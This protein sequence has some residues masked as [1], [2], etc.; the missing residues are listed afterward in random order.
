MESTLTIAL[1]STSAEFL[2]A[3]MDEDNALLSASKA[4]RMLTVSLI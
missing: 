2:T 3:L 1:L 4:F